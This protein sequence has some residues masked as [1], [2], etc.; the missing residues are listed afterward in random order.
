MA[1]CKLCK[2]HNG[3]QEREQQQWDTRPIQV[4]VVNGH[5]QQ[6]RLVSEVLKGYR[7]FTFER[8]EAALERLYAERRHQIDL[9]MR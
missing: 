5:P 3:L 6:L 4:L 9:L 1:L 2:T 8:P 7:V